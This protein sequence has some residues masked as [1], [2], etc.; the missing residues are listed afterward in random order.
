VK[1]HIIRGICWPVTWLE[2]EHLCG[3]I[4]LALNSIAIPS[5]DFLFF[6]FE[7]AGEKKT[8]IGSTSRGIVAQRK[9]IEG[10]DVENF[11]LTMTSGTIHVVS[12]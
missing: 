5:Y 11:E 7:W 9:A 12:I 8:G 3:T 4:L 2:L 10:Y 1:Q 6:G